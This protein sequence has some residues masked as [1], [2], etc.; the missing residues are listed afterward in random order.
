MD[1]SGSIS[2]GEAA[3]CIGVSRST[4][5]RK[6]DAGEI[7]GYTNPVT[8]VRQVFVSSLIEFM[9]TRGLPT[10]K[11]SKGLKRIV[12]AAGNRSFCSAVMDIC[13]RDARLG[14]RSVSQ[15]SD[16]LAVCS[17]E[18]P[19]LFLV[20][21]DLPDIA[22]SDVVK[23]LRR[24][25]NLKGMKILCYAPQ[26]DASTCLEPYADVCVDDASIESPKALMT[27]IYGLLSLSPGTEPKGETV[28]RRRWHR[29]TVDIPVQV[30]V[31]RRGSQRAKWPSGTGILR[32]ASMGGAFVADLEFEGGLPG[33]AFRLLLR[34]SSG[35]LPDWQAYCRLVRLESNG[36]LSAGLRFVRMSKSAR[37][38]LHELVG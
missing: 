12:L 11:L 10:D 1:D 14:L 16:A 7:E 18:C 9:R 3:R 30:D 6:F 5:I 37:E 17:R 21:N 15:G 36:S 35:M 19:D 22:C 13:S 34:S 20:G 26:K 31:Y 28:H 25:A 8:G 4:L 33:G 27:Q 23:S 32:N 2:T 38:R 24:Q 29:T